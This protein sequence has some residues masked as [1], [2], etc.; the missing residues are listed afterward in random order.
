[1]ATDFARIEEEAVRLTDLLCRLPSVSAE[2]RALDETAAVVEELLA[3]LGF[4]TRRL[5]AD[6][7][8][9][10]VWG[11]QAGRSNY[12]VL[13]YNHYDVQPVD[14]LDLWD[15]PPFEP[16][17]R[18]GRLFARGAS[19]NKGEL[20]VRLAVLK[21]LREEHGELPLRVRWIIEGEEEIGSPN[22]DEIVRRNVDVL[23]A[24]G[25]LWEGGSAREA[26]GRPGIALGFKGLLGIRLDV[27]KLATDAHSSLA[28][29]APSAAW[30]LVNALASLR[31]KDG[32]VVV[33]GF[34][35][36]VLPPTDAE[37]RVIAEAGAGDAEV[38]LDTLGLAAFVDGLTGPALDERASFR[39]TSNIAGIHTGYGGPGFKTVL[40]KE[41]SAWMDFRLVPDQR[42][43]E[44]LEL[45]RDHLVMHGFDDIEVTLVS[46]ARP[47]KTAVDHPFVQQIASIA[48][49]V[50]GQPAS[51]NPLSAATLPIVAS[52]AEHL[53]V[54]GL[55]AP[56]NP[57]YGGSRA[58]APN[59]HIRLDDIGPAVRFTHAVLQQLG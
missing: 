25:S 8:P 57:T 9:D 42:P 39:P 59:E 5:R 28:A 26:D 18:D 50:S 21:A 56:D 53:G 34:Y 46:I 19:D 54:P 10:A 48:E 43:E 3:E 30:R 47:A 23:R 6:A 49:S 14:P 24:D 41:A 7:G 32:N 2:G 51:I 58:H 17:V 45:V 37:R 35:D 11:E 12:T 13:L 31:D 16:V 40:P 27:R 55:S 52:F 4:E 44:I 15:S 29:I 38:L 33:A 20:A 1:M 22:F 36:R